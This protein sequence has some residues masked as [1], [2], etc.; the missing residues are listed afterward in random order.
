MILPLPIVD[1]SAEQH[2]LWARVSELWAMMK[3]RDVDQIRATPHPDY[4]G[5]GMSAPLQHDR[6]A[7][8][9]SVTGDAPP[10]VEHDLTPLSVQIYDETVGIVHYL[11]AATVQP[12]GT[13][14]SRCALPASDLP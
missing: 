1:F 13:T 11:Y 9:Q 6:D 8:A 7:A 3:V 2:E 10:L 4:V 14:P 12:D 5:W